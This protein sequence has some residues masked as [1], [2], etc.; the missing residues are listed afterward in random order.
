MADWRQDTDILR[1]NSK[2]YGHPRYDC[3]M[4]SAT[5][6]PFF[7]CLMPMFTCVVGSWIESIALIQ[8]FDQRPLSQKDQDLGF[9]RVWE[10]QRGSLA[11]FVSL[12]SVQ[13]GELLVQDF[14]KSGDYLVHDLVDS[15]MFLRVR[16]LK[17]EPAL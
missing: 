11:E 3:A 17:A 15:D 5:P 7:G 13:R 12:H 1:C 4:F 10:R 14:E 9:Y 2:F 16:E 8:S 6:S